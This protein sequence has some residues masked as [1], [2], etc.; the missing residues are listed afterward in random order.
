MIA[1][2]VGFE[3]LEPAVELLGVEFA[4]RRS[5][6]LEVGLGGEEI[7]VEVSG[8]GQ[9]EFADLLADLGF[10]GAKLAENWFVQVGRIDGMADL[11]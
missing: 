10:E 8:V 1:G 4:W 11:P 2:W 7:A 3:G 6:M 5:G 9:P